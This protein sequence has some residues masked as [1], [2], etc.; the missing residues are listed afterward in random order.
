MTTTSL[1]VLAALWLLIS[2][3]FIMWR[4]TVGRGVGLVVSIVLS[5]SAIHWVATALYLLP[6]YDNLDRD[7]VATGFWTA[8][9]GLC[10]F[11]L[12]A[13]IM[14]RAATREP[15]RAGSGEPPS[16]LGWPYLLIGV[17]MYGI[18]WPRIGRI[19]SIGALVAAGSNY[20]VLGI[21]LRCWK[22]DTARMARWVAASTLL[23]FATILAQGYLS[24]GLAA[25][26]GVAA[27]IAEMIKSRKKLVL[28]GVGVGYVTMSFFVTYMRDRAQIRDAV[29]NG[30]ETSQRIDLISASIANFEWFD[31]NNPSHLWRIDE[32][33]NQG[34]LVGLA[35]DRLER[36]DVAFGKGETVKDAFIALLPRML[37]PDKGVAAG[38]SDIVSRYTGMEFMEGTSVGV[39]LVMELFVNFGAPGVWIGFAAFGALLIFIDERA[40]A[41]LVEGDARTFAVWYLPGSSLLQLGGGS[42]V[43]A[44]ASAG[45]A[46]VSV[47]LV[48]ALIAAVMKR[49]SRPAPDAWVGPRA[50][51]ERLA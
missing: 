13:V 40:H 2:A 1:A 17:V 26:A 12:G 39:G 33:L 9:Q 47:L 41:R 25:L 20:I 21:C 18:L 38:S 43:D 22:A 5:L 11:C 28:V 46:L 42:L 45:A 30:A 6:W 16:A 8:F 50:E 35:V 49:R 36:G 14:S 37:W 7:V 3:A 51:P 32:R 31:I 29:W 27:F 48:N 4:W 15:P 34:Y 19:A 23:P 44:S 10:A 24:Y